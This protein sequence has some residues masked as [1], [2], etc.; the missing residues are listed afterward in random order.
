MSRRMALPRAERVR[1]FAA[2]GCLAAVL[3]AGGCATTSPIHLGEHAERL[4][5]FDRAVVAPDHQA[6]LK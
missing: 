1:A 6:C 3:T 4:Q 5:D 2:V